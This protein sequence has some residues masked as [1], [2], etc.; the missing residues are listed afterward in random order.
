MKESPV[1]VLKKFFQ[2]IVVPFDAGDAFAAAHVADEVHL[3]CDRRT[4]EK[5]LLGEAVLTPSQN[6]YD[7]LGSG[8]YFWE[9]GPER[10][11]QWAQ[12]GSGEPAG[13]RVD[14][15]HFYALDFDRASVLTSSDGGQTFSAANTTGL[16]REVAVR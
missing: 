4:A 16:P 7:W 15:R 2:M 14:A 12:E 8:V 11:L 1:E 3:G 10:A 5:V 9:F 13:D 6:N